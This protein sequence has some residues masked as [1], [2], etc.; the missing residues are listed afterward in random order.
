[1][2]SARSVAVRS[3]LAAVLITLPA[4]ALTATTRP[5]PLFG[6]PI[7]GN[8]AELVTMWPTGS[9]GVDSLRITDFATPPDALKPR[10]SAACPGGPSTAR[11]QQLDVVTGDFDGD[12]RDDIVSAHTLPTVDTWI[13]RLVLEVPD[14]RSGPLDWV[15]AVSDTQ[16]DVAVERDAYRSP[17]NVRLAAGHF[18][19]DLPM[20]LVLATRVQRNFRGTLVAGDA[21]GYAASAIGDVDGDGV[22]DLAVTMPQGKDGG[23]NRGA[24]WILYLRGDGSVRTQRKISSTDG[25]FTGP[26]DD[27]DY[28]GSSVAAAGDH[29]GDG[30]PDIAV[31]AWGDDDG[32]SAH[33][34]VWL[35]HLNRDGTVKSQLKISSTSG[36]FAGALDIDDQFG[37]G[38]ASLGD[39]DG[40]GYVDLAV[41]APGD[42]DGGTD[43]GAVWILFLDG[44]GVK[45][46][47]KITNTGGADGDLFGRGLAYCPDFGG[48]RLLAVGAPNDDD[49]GPNRGAVW[50]LFLN[51]DG[52]DASR[53]RISGT[54][55][56]FTGRLDD[57]DTFGRTIAIVPDRDLDG[58]PELAVSSDG[59][60]DGGTDR[61]AVYIVHPTATRTVQSAEKISQTSGNF[62]GAIGNYDRFGVAVVCPG[63]LDGDGVADLVIGAPYADVWGPPGSDPFDPNRWDSGDLWFVHLNA[64]GDPVK[65]QMENGTWWEG[66][67]Q[68]QL[69]EL[70][71][72][73]RPVTV[74]LRFC[75][76]QDD[77]LKE[78]T[79]FDVATGDFD[80]NGID[81]IAVGGVRR[82]ADNGNM[83]LFVTI[84][85][86]QDGELVERVTS[87]S[88][89]QPQ[90]NNALGLGVY[91]DH[92]ALATGRL[93]QT[94]ADQI[95]FSWS[96]RDAQWSEDVWGCTI[97]DNEWEFFHSTRNT[98][99]T[100]TVGTA[101]WAIAG[102]GSDPKQKEIV[103]N[104]VV[105][106]CGG[107][108]DPQWTTPSLGVAA[109]DLTGDG[110][111]EVAWS[112]T[113]G[114]YVYQVDVGDVLVERVSVT[115][116]RV[117]RDPARRVVE[118]ADLDATM[119]ATGWRPELIVQDWGGA[120]T[121]QR[122][123]VFQAVTD[124]GGVIT[125][126][127]ARG[128]LTE[129]Q[130]PMVQG[131]A[132]L[133]C[134]DFDGDGIRLGAPTFR[135]VSEVTRPLVMLGAP[136]VHF[137]VINGQAYDINGCYPGDGTYACDDFTA[138]YSQETTTGV[139]VEVEN[140]RDWG[141]SAGIKGWGEA[142]GARV[143]SS[144]ETTYGQ[145]FSRVQNRNEAFSYSTMVT[146]Q[147]RDLIL[148]DQVNYDLW[149]Y[150]VRGAGG[151]VLGHVA[152]IDPGSEVQ[153]RGWEPYEEW[154]MRGGAMAIPHEPGN[155]LSYPK[156]TLQTD[157]YGEGWK[158]DVV[159]YTVA[160]PLAAM[161]GTALD[162]PEPYCFDVVWDDISGSSVAKSWNAGLEVGASVSYE[163]SDPFGMFKAGVS[164]D[165]SGHYDASEMTTHRVT[166]GEAISM[167]GA[168]GTLAPNQPATY[169]VYPFVYR[170]TTSG[171]LVLD[172]RVVPTG[173]FWSAYN[174][175]D[176]TFILPRLHRA[177]KGDTTDP[178]MRY[179]TPDIRI[180][181]DAV[182]VG[183]TVA[184]RVEV[185]N[186][187]LV[188]H[189]GPVAMRL[190]SGDPDG[191]NTPIHDIHGQDTFTLTGGIPSREGRAIEVQ[192]AVPWYTP[193]TVKVFAQI[194]PDAAVSEIHEDNNKGFAVLAATG[195]D[196]LDVPT[197][198]AVTPFR[199]DQAVPSPFRGST[200]IAFGMPERAH[201]ELSVFDVAG[202]RIA[203]LVDEE[204][205]PGRHQYR[206]DGRDRDGGSVRPGIY[207]CRLRAGDHHETRRMVRL[208]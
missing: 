10:P 12:G 137:D 111:D 49:G 208:N 44:A 51:P 89:D 108:Y 113:D 192:W 81:E 142:F 46:H 19:A 3:L 177:A 82:R 151:Q 41:A 37:L 61:G 69:M 147:G 135:S 118:I 165:V 98:L 54:S 92:V 152:V 58:V 55:P 202:R 169:K 62:G 45:A 4:T 33:G 52:S 48:E 50:L 124:G 129:A 148:A 170:S 178:G 116:P 185:R 97:F 181:P 168:L 101:P 66:M 86:Y 200:M 126:L 57:N 9:N 204:L 23:A 107:R 14:I 24:V 42:D 99:E 175:P 59:D 167:R 139:E 120:S 16:G 176:L 32:G 183:D 76:P 95:L 84:Y 196:P 109:G 112:T 26:L 207:L 73:R 162:C 138:S 6:N 203:T 114:I 106:T 184:I 190:F 158:A 36:G 197:Q 31:G 143:E 119:G 173:S 96:R 80:G 15:T 132:A 134:G 25:G 155:I 63:D 182:A 13:Q 7:L 88:G 205:G 29:D 180:T 8:S 187:G 68:L 115:R 179:I 131:D 127:A 130:V 87:V 56:N 160:S 78:S 90:G 188:D 171:V 40:D 35:L 64:I 17:S 157:P 39:F 198:V 194:D 193:S 60:D 34:A 122:I 172:Y 166:V 144:F 174:G 79:R 77:A 94:L 189:A 1:M 71:Q 153:D 136:P 21:F 65:G 100:L 156:T 67:L 102:W 18:D 195:G 154:I 149:E 11:Y 121:T 103:G 83:E 70:D 43:R 161:E 123:R 125:A 141:L 110:V 186:F 201:V 163:A 20:E 199:L 85:A 28:F 140:T 104:K 75:Q 27:L 91:I 2:L 30:V 22:G 145:H 74:A 150:P 38:V 5:H 117:Y 159:G 128:Q 133:V 164:V 206:W 53:A 146:T 93:R 191:V 72:D 47:R 105:T